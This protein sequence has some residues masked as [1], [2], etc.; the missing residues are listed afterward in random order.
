MQ[1]LTEIP[2]RRDSARLFAPIAA[3]PWGVFLDSGRPFCETGRYDI[4]TADPYMTLVTRGTVTEISTRAGVALSP[5]DPFAL[6]R[7][8]LGERPKPL[9]QPPRATPGE[10]PAAP[11]DP[12]FRGGAAGWFGYDLGRRIER[13]PVLAEDQEQIPD[14]AVGLYDWALVVDHTERRS[15]LVSAGRDART[16]EHWADLVMCFSKPGSR[17]AAQFHITGPVRSNMTQAQYKAAFERVQAYI[18]DGDCYQVNLA[19]RFVAPAAG[20]A[21]SAY[22]QLRQ[23]NPA[24]FSA[25]LS[26]PFAKVMSSSPERFLQLRNGSVETRP[27]KG[28]RPRGSNP[29]AD[30][31]LAR[32]LSQSPKDRAENLMILDLMRNDLGR[33]CDIG[34]VRV[35]RLFA[36]ERFA[37]IHHLVSTV[38]GRLAAGEDAASLLRACFPGGSITGAPKIRAMEIIEALEPHRRG[39]YCGAIGYLGFDGAMDTNIAIR[40]LVY[41]AGTVRLWA[42]GGIVHDSDV[43]QEYQE[44]FDKAAP[45]LRLLQGERLAR[46]GP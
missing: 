33:V 15:W 24:P 30:A 45:L 1:L 38:T 26:T 31:M 35:P 6:L 14:M 21:W 17:P 10:S 3:R 18:L 19:Q 23:L 37:N 32:A 43:E 7:R 12:P 40:T 13:L 34:S 27:I 36:V 4:L 42:G 28:T 8:A 46:V 9:A 16:R 11:A 44:T 41:G 29:E 5:E 20:N 39:V 25:Y 2:Y 22:R